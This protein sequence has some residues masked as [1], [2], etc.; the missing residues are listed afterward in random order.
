MRLLLLV[1]KANAS[2]A[3]K[4]RAVAGQHDFVVP[5][6]SGVS[7]L[8]THKMTAKKLKVD[9]IVCA[10]VNTLAKLVEA[11]GQS[12][13]RGDKSI[14]LRNY[15][16]SVYHIGDYPVVVMDNLKSIF[17]F[18]YGKWVAQRYIN[19]ITHDTP[20]PQEPDFIYTPFEGNEQ[21]ILELAEKSLMTAVDIETI[22]APVDVGELSA[23]C[24]EAG[25]TSQGMWAEMKLNSSSK[26]LTPCVP[27]IDMVGYSF[28]LKG[29]DNQL[30]SISTTVPFDSL[31]NLNFIRKLNSTKA[32]K[33]LQNGG[34]DSTY[35][36]RFGCPMYNWIYD[37]YHYMHSWQ[38]ELPRDLGFIGSLFLSKHRYWK[39]EI[40]TNRLE[41]CAKD[42]HGTLWCMLIMVKEAPHWVML[43]YQTLFRKVFPNICAGLE[44]DCI[45]PVERTKLRNHY[46]EV[47]AD[48]EE[49]L[50]T[51]VGGNFNP[52]SSQQ[53]LKL[54]RGL[55]L[56]KIRYESSDKVNMRRW[57]EEHPLNTHIAELISNAREARKKISTYINATEFDG[58]LLYEINS[59]GTDTGRAAS[60]SSNL[61]T[62]TQRQNI[63]GKVKSMFVADEGWEYAAC[64]GS[65]AESRTTAYISED[66]N[67]INAVETAPDF[68]T[69]NA[70]M[71]FGMEENEI[72]KVIRTL[73]KRVNHGANYNMGEGVLI[74]TMGMK[75]ILE[76]KYLL[77]LSHVHSLKGVA[78]HLLNCFDQTY[79]LL[80]TKYYDEVIEEVN[81]TGMLKL[82][83]DE[84][85]WIRLCHGSPSRTRKRD[86][87]L[88]VAHMP[89]SLSSQIIDKAW[90]DFW[91]KWQIQNNVVRVKAQVHDEIQWQTPINHPLRD[92]IDN[93][94]KALMSRYY[95]VRGRQ[96]RIPAD[97]VLHGKRL[98]DVKD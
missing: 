45:D 78:T 40:G 47:L 25:T 7:V 39:N 24:A 48:A 42:V 62:G 61:W 88:Y 35:F 12:V 18:N 84:I 64:D 17:A 75:M 79:P 97:E 13:P 85:H 94:A 10:C 28:L 1:D 50:D 77:G 22:K 53:V 49:K 32:P 83:C 3:Q 33:V 57:A 70:S 65:Q 71:F 95:T 60:K 91:Y 74:E 56:A 6:I 37:T 73:G 31:R 46:S 29:E 87:N 19:K 93:D 43:N 52:N 16:G 2:H 26:K 82:P 41:Y 92:E 69:R 11:D 67:L 59:S 90:F 14:S 51:I 15:R 72:S 5:K 4:L 63:D 58:R 8:A 96:L 86:L 68:H 76:A 27:T 38:A 21:H 55:S 81:R 98:S 66:P 20:T 89:Q 44:G 80:R 23:L 34:Y 36:I 9:A 30:Y 54:M